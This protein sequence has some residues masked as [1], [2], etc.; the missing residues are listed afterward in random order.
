MISVTL[1]GAIYRL[2]TLTR[3]VNI[4]SVIDDFFS[5]EIQKIMKDS[6]FTINNHCRH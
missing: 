2:S 6:V 1:N 3:M 5:G 4:F